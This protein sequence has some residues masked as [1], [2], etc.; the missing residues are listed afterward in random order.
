MTP[1]FILVLA[2]PLGERIGRLQWLGVAISVLRV[3]RHGAGP[4]CRRST[5]AT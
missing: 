3:Y 1:I 5:S 4:P 2:A